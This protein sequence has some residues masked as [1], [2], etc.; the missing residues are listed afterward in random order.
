M[1]F[2]GPWVST[3]DDYG[4]HFV[5]D[6]GGVSVA[7]MRNY[8][9]EAHALLIAAAPRMLAALLRAAERLEKVYADGNADYQEIL[10][11]IEDATKQSTTA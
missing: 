7:V 6:N 11:V 3:R 8:N 9:R 10:D 5:E 4:S 2:N 1:L